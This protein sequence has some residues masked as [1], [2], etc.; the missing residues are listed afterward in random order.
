MTTIRIP[1][2]DKL[3]ADLEASQVDS[4]EP[5]PEVRAQAIEAARRHIASGKAVCKECDAIITPADKAHVRIFPPLGK[6]LYRELVCSRC[7]Q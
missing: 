6:L 7:M 1:L 3:R 2:D 5:T 4:Y